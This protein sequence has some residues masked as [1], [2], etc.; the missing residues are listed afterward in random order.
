MAK[1]GKHVVVFAEDLEPEHSTVIKNAC[2]EVF[3]SPPASGAVYGELARRIRT[4]VDKELGG[5]GWT[6]I[7]GKSFGA[8]VTHKIKCYAYLSVFPGVNV[9]VWR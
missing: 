2:L 6:V 1:S 9:L 7:V 4:I 8:Y 3:E 5:R